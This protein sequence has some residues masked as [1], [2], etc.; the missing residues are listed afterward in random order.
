MRLAGAKLLPCSPFTILSNLLTLVIKCIKGEREE[1]KSS[2][3][4]N[5]G[6]VGRLAG[7]AMQRSITSPPAVLH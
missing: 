4:G 1:E 6:E 7:D 5:V 3:K 2:Y